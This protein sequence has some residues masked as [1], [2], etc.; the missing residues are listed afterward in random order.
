MNILKQATYSDPVLEGG[1]FQEAREKVHAEING[2]SKGGNYIPK[3]EVI[4]FEKYAKTDTDKEELKAFKKRN[5][6]FLR[7]AGLDPKKHM[8]DPKSNMGVIKK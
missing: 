6:D 7:R 5:K 1:K 3:A 8:N 4:S 2:V